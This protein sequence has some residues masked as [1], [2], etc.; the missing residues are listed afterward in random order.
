MGAFGFLYAAEST[1]QALVDVGYHK[2]IGLK[3]AL[4]VLGV[5][6]AFGFFC[7]FLVPETNQ[8][9]LEEISG[10]NVDDDVVDPLDKTRAPT[11][12]M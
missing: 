6:N 5:I 9:S 7:T 10:E 4:I 3:N 2:G 8:R 11:V 12:V 1:H